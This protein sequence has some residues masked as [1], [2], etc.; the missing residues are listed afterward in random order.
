MI[1][2]PVNAWPL[3]SAAVTSV[4][5]ALGYGAIALFVER[6]RAADSRFELTPQRNSLRPRFP[7]M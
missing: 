6:A 5:E 7:R 2:G 3:A 4:A 1:S